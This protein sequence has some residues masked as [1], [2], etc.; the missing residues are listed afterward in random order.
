MNFSKRI[1]MLRILF[2]WLL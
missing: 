1:G 2:F